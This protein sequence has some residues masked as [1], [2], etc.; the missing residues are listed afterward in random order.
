MTQTAVFLTWLAF[1]ETDDQ[2][3]F[4]KLRTLFDPGAYGFAQM[5]EFVTAVSNPGAVAF[6]GI[7][8][9]AVGSFALEFLSL[10]G[11][12]EPYLYLRR[13]SVSIIAIVLTIILGS[14]EQNAFIYFAF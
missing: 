8:I 9:I 5:R 10:K 3:L 4:K 7:L 14:G 6:L 11:G 1:Y 12:N 2:M 13:T